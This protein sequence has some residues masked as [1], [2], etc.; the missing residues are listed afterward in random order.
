MSCH[1]TWWHENQEDDGYREV[2]NAPVRDHTRP[3]CDGCCNEMKF[4]AT[5]Y[6]VHEIT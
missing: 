6:K 3:I 2:Y 1:K 5:G 4:N